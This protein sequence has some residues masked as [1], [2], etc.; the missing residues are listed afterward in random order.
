MDVRTCN[1]SGILITFFRIFFNPY[2]SQIRQIV[3]NG[4]I[5]EIMP[6]MAQ[7]IITGFARM[8][9]HTVGVVG[10][11][12]LVLAGCL[13]INASNKAARFVRFCDA[14]NIPLVT[15]VDV[16]GELRN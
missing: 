13:D 1:C 10:N 9:G 14:F 4:D 8:D 6:K 2:Y 3:D 7:N 12:P 11:N 15:L 5:F 16:P